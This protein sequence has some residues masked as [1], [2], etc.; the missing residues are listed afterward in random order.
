MSQMASEGTFTCLTITNPL[1]CIVFFQQLINHSKSSVDFQ[2]QN[3]IDLDTITVEPDS[4]TIS[5]KTR[6]LAV[7]LGIDGIFTSFD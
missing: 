1:T 6:W 5:K 2:W 4:G 7:K 3:E